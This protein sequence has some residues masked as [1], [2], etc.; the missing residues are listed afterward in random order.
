MSIYKPGRP[1]KYDPSTG[2]GTRPPASSGE[3]R[4]RDDRGQIVY[5]GETNNLQRRTNEHIRSGKMVT[6]SGPHSTIEYKVA[7]ADST[8]ATRRAHEQQKIAQH[9]PALNRSRGGE[10]RPAGK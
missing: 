10:G 4:I 5:I 8:S 9:K 1:T 7:S 3:Y 2:I 6:G